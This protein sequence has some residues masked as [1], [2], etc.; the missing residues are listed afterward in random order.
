MVGYVGVAGFFQLSQRDFCTAA[1]AA[2]EVDR[3][4]FIRADGFDA[5]NDLVMRNIEC[6]L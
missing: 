2:V 3:C 4:V 5:V 1:A 6:T